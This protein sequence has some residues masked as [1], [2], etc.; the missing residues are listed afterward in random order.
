MWAL[1]CFCRPLLCC[2]CCTVY[3]PSGMLTRCSALLCATTVQLSH[4][5]VSGLYA[6]PTPTHPTLPLPP[7]TPDTP[8]LLTR[9]D[10]L[11]IGAAS[12]SSAGPLSPLLIA[13]LRHLGLACNQ[14]WKP[15]RSRRGGRNEPRKISIEDQWQR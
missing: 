4:F 14:P 3:L 7:L 15:R 2:L 5:S 6:T 10:L 13:R 11:D 9:Q 8:T 12:S 1:C